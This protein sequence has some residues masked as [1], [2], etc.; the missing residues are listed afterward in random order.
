MQKICLNC[1]N[2]I[3]DEKRKK[4]CCTKCYNEYKTK[5]VKK[6]ERQCIV[7]SNILGPGKRKFCGRECAAK[8]AAMQ[9]R[10]YNK[11]MYTKVYDLK[12]KSKK[13]TRKLDR[14]SLEYINELARAEGLSYGQYVGKHGL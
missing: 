4:F 10:A 11:D 13:N 5:R 3:L 1:S 7:C 9:R 2:A 14:N 12:S 8:Y 6:E